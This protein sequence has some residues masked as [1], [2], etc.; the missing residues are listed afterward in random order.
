LEASVRVLLPAIALSWCLASVAA[1]RVLVVGVDGGSWNVID[2][3][4]AAGELPHLAELIER[5]VS[6]DLATVEPVTS[7]VVWTSIATGRGPEAHGVTDFFS[8]RAH[9]KVPTIYERLAVSGLRVGLYDVLMTWPP[10][11]LPG[12]FVVPGW[13]R[14]DETTWP[15]DALATDGPPLFRTVYQAIPTNREYLEQARREG[16]EKLRALGYIE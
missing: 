9:V 11:S 3:L 13:L 1:A 2:P 15:P 16:L 8:T 6:A 12:G 7:P 14:R 4:L 10:A 5:G